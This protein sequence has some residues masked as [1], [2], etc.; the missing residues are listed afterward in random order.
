M[1]VFYKDLTTNI[2]NNYLLK[3]QVLYND[4]PADIGNFDFYFAT[5]LEKWDDENLDLIGPSDPEFS[6]LDPVNTVIQF[7]FR[8][9]RDKGYFLDSCLYQVRM[10]NRDNDDAFVIMQGRFILEDSLFPV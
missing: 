5:V 2:D 7:N 6:I 9:T 8:P 10:V 1:S 4:L 3:I